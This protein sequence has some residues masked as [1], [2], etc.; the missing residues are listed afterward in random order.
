VEEKMNRT[1]DVRA[2]YG[3]YT[4]TFGVT[5][6]HFYVFERDIF[7]GMDKD[8]NEAIALIALREGMYFDPDKVEVLK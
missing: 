3:D 1:L 2:R 4:I 8:F 5:H 7:V 6:G